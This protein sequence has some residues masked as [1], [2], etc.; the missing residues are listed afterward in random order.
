MISLSCGAHKLLT[1]IKWFDRKFGECFPKQKFLAVRLKASISSVQRWLSELVAAGSVTVIRRGPRGST[2]LPVNKLCS[3]VQNEVDHE[4]DLTMRPILLSGKTE[5]TTAK[6]APCF[7]K[8]PQ[9]ELQLPSPTITNEYG[10]TDINP[11][12]QRMQEILRGAAGRIASARN[13]AAYE[14][15]ILTR[16]MGLKPVAAMAQAGVTRRDG[17]QRPDDGTRKPPTRS[18]SSHGENSQVLVRSVLAAH[19]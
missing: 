9:A 13:P 16:E 19:A 11:E 1:L 12:W 15:A 2:Y 8:R 14:R 4:V 6:N 10:R 7:R 5:E 17:I 3:A 18:A